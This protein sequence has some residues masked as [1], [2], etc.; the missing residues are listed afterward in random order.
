MEANE[1]KDIRKKI[2]GMIIP[3]TSEN[4][5]QMIAGT[6]TMAFMG[7]LDAAAVGA[8]GIGNIIFRMAW[9]IFRG[10]GIGASA[11]ISRYYGSEDYTGILKLMA[12]G[13]MSVVAF[14]L[15]VQQ[16]VYRFAVYLIGFL[17]SG[18]GLVADALMFTKI[19]SLSIPFMAIVVFS[20]GIFQGM[21]N[22]KTPMYAVGIMNAVNIILSYLLIFGNMGFPALGIKGAAYAF[23]LAQLGAALFSIVTLGITAKKLKLLSNRQLLV[24]GTSIKELIRYGFPSAMEMLM[25]QLSSVILTK[26]VLTYGETAYASYQ[27]GLQ[28]EAISYMPAAGFSIAATAFIG[29]Q[30]GANDF[31][32]S[33]TYMNELW[34][35]V[36]GITLLMASALVFIPG[37]VMRVLTDDVSMIEIGKMY[38]IVMG[39]SQLPQNLAGLYNG[40]LRGAGHPNVPM[41]TTMVGVWFIRIPLVIFLAYFLEAKLYWIW[42]AMALDLFSRYIL[43]RI[44]FKKNVEGKYA[45]T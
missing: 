27:L 10:V 7:R 24:N 6:V 23:G 18:E 44:S 38:L 11:A 36:V 42:I 26:A 29:Q 32:Q 9:S 43:S 16:I 33:R 21:T 8:V 40:A 1:I 30:L 19:V 31:K 14:A 22:S 28:A 3:I 35:M 2:L 20:A 5:L 4:L 34:K 45:V 15:V 37:L 13:L 17:S 41:M 39:V 12:E 25:W